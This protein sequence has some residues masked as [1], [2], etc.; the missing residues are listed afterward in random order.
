MVFHQNVNIGENQ[1][2]ALLEK[3]PLACVPFCL[4]TCQW[5]SPARISACMTLATLL[6]ALRK[7]T[8]SRLSG[9]LWD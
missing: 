1:C 6:V 7:Q 5:L 4:C 8:S 3:P 9:L 2:F